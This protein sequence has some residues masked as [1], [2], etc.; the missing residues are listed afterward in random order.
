MTTRVSQSQNDEELYQLSKEQLVEIIK[1]L[2]EKIARLE[3]SL[4]LDSKTSSKPPSADLLK[5]SEKKKPQPDVEGTTTKR[6][7]G[8]QPGHEGKTRKGFGRFDRIEI[9]RPDVCPHCGGRHVATAPV[10]IEVQQVAQLV[11][12]PIEIVEY[13]R[14]HYQCTHCGTSCAADWSQQMIPGQD[15]GV[16]Q[17]SVN[18]LVGQLRPHA[19]RKNP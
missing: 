4:N 3:E 2:Q 17:K 8:G 15:I 18:W 14:H 9:L 16:Q 19:L 6:K 13:H 7:P 10:N 1:T 12:N 5:K 11:T